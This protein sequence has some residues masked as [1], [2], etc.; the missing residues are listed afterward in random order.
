MPGLYQVPGGLPV[1][2]GQRLMPAMVYLLRR[3]KPGRPKPGYVEM[4]I[5]A[6]AREWKLPERYIPLGRALV[7]LALPPARA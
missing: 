6:A 5:A 7:A 2:S 3:R 4:I 1:R